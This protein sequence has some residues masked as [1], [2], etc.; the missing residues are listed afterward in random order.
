M[1]TSETIVNTLNTIR[2]DASEEYQNSVP[3]AT[4]TNLT[5]VGNPI[6]NYTAIHNEFLSALVNRI[7]M[8]VVN[9]REMR[10]PLSILKQGE[11]TF[12]QDVQEIYTN[13]ATATPYNS[14]STD[15]LSQTIPDTKCI[16]HRLNRQDRYTVTVRDEQLRLAFI[17]FNSF[18]SLLTSIINSLYN[19]NYIDEFKLCKQLFNSAVQN[20]KIVKQTV[21]NVTDE[22]TAKNFI[23]ECRKTFK[24][25]AIP[26]ENYNAWTV[27]GGSGNPVTAMSMPEDVRFILRS[28]IESFCDVNVLASAFNLSKTDFLGQLLIVDS[29]ADT[30]DNILGIMCDKN[31]TQIYDKLKETRDFYN[32]SNLTWNYYLHIWQVYSVSTLVNGVAFISG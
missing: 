26:S 16:Y 2:A 10:N 13:P 31:Y 1:A 24:N 12:G 32:P 7:A 29:F 6:M 19:G 28:D 17:N 21:P 14:Q 11:I 22:S 15:L 23:K 25:M 20:N 8:T 9:A 27:S 4:L 5:D 30:N 18:N 3:I